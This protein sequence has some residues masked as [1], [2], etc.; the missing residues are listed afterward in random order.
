MAVRQQVEEGL[1]C[2][3]VVNITA[4][5]KYNLLLDASNGPVGPF[6][7]DEIHLKIN[8]GE[9]PANPMITQEG[10]TQ[11]RPLMGAGA[12][13]VARLEGFLP[14]VTS[15]FLGWFSKTIPLPVLNGSLEASRSVS[16]YNIIIGA[17]LLVVNSIYFAIKF[18]SWSV[19][20]P[21][22]LLVLFLVAGQLFAGRFLATNELLIN[23]SPVRRPPVAVIECAALL[24][25]FAS[26]STLIAAIIV[27]VHMNE[28]M[29]F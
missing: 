24:A 4:M 21:G 28:A 12:T 14:G 7:L 5:T 20:I 2:C 3:E 22:L 15:S 25:L 17:A 26:L 11:W 13:G 27:C 29:P 19:L 6:S 18:R 23:R 8:A 1:V 10:E 16:G 9:L